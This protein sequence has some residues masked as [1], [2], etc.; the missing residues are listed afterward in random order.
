MMELSYN[1]EELINKIYDVSEGYHPVCLVEA[2]TEIFDEMS[3][4][5][6]ER[7]FEDP[8]LMKKIHYRIVVEGEKID[9]NYVYTKGGIHLLK[10]AGRIEMPDGVYHVDVWIS[11]KAD[12]DNA[13]L[14]KVSID[15]FGDAADLMGVGSKCSAKGAIIEG[16]SSYLD[17]KDIELQNVVDIL[18]GELRKFATKCE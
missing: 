3:E 2:I 1:I 7:T 10:G 13:H 18:W 4:K 6:V 8:E 5:L 15:L 17:C 16:L 14:T 11:V 12:E 9:C